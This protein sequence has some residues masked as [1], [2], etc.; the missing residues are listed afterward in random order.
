[1]VIGSDQEKCAVTARSF[2]IWAEE[3]SRKGRYA[4]A[5]KLYKRALALVER[6]LGPSHP[7]T[8]EVLECY[9]DLLGKTSRGS[10]AIA[11][12]DRAASVWRGY[13]PRFCRIYKDAHPFPICAQDREGSD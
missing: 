5:E 9:A 12:R 11:M 4:A 10:E 6:T 7:M 2:V 13:A 3:F 1:M 8:A